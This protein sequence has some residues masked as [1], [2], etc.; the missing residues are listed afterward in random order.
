M[1]EQENTAFR[2]GALFR[3]LIYRYSYK[4]FFLRLTDIK[5]IVHKGDL[6]TL[7]YYR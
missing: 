4:A 1:L 5:L 7:F 2:T 3:R 6:E